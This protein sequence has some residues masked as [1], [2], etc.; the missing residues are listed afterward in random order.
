LLITACGDDPEVDVGSDPGATP[1]AEAWGDWPVSADGAVRR[2]LARIE[3]ERADDPDVSEDWGDW[4]VTA[5][6]AIRRELARL[7]AEHAA[8]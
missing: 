8:D 4:P 7:E 1:V 6:G 3:A 5:D 2:E